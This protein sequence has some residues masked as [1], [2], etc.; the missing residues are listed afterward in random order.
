[1][2]ANTG[3]KGWFY[4]S[5]PRS[6]RPAGNVR[7]RPA[8]GRPACR[9]G[10]DRRPRLP[11]ALVASLLGSLVGMAGAAGALAGP[12]AGGGDGSGTAAGSTAPSVLPTSIPFPA[13]S[14]PALPGLP[15]LPPLQLPPITLA[16]LPPLIGGA[17]TGVPV[18]PAGLSAYQGLAGWIDLYDYGAPGDPTPAA[19]VSAMAARHVHTLYVQTARWDSANDL[20]YPDALGGLVDEAHAQGLKVVG[21]YLPGFANQALDLRRS[22]AVLDFTSPRGGHMDGFAADIEDHGATGSIGQFNAGIV[23][24]VQ[25]LRAAVTPGTVIAAIVPDAKNNERAPAHW[26]GFPWP[27]IGDNFDVVLPMAYWSVTKNPSTCLKTQMDVTSYMD[28]VIG[29]TTSLLGVSRPLAPM[30]GIADC[31]T[32]REVAEYVAVLKAS[33]AIG[34]GLYDFF[35]TQARPDASTVW[36]ELAGLNS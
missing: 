15:A 33:G 30:G 23:S 7:V 17:P 36:S 10:R 27:Q 21:W 22:L 2:A 11:I 19:I 16:A 20:D 14:F 13:I 25:A 32:T 35:T 24:Y 4:R 34:G 8:R 9:A 5:P 26:A 28:Q 3:L 6:R 12:A 29:L 18:G 1:M 31:D